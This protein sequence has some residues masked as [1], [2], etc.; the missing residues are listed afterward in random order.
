MFELILNQPLQPAD[1]Y[2]IENQINRTIN[3][4]G[5]HEIVLL[6]QNEMSQFP[7]IDLVHFTRDALREVWASN[8][9]ITTKYLATLWWG[10]VNFR[11]F[12]RVFSARSMDRLQDI[13]VVLEER[14]AVLSYAIDRVTLSDVFMRMLLPNGELKVPYVGP[15]FFTKILQFYVAAHQRDDQ[16][17]LPIIADQWLMKALYCE[18]TDAGS[19]LR[20]DIFVIGPNGISLQDIPESY[21]IYVEWFNHRCQGYNVTPWEMEGRLFRNPVVANYYNQLVANV[22]QQHQQKQIVVNVNPV[23]QNQAVFLKVYDKAGRNYGKT[24]QIMNNHWTLPHNTPHVYVEWLGQTY[25]AAN[26][27]YSGKGNTLR[28]KSTIKELINRN[29]WQ[30]GD[31]FSCEF[32]VLQDAHV[33][34]ILGRQ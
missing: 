14:L 13:S 11:I 2:N 23:P 15:A 31:A 12:K 9:H 33:Y 10:N 5:G 22:M 32:I 16:V 18:M 6:A 1:G 19:G 30:P 34:R 24:F 21:F 29:H 8:C 7:G 25:E 27:T 20:D 28:G 4:S 3:V 17:L 26:R